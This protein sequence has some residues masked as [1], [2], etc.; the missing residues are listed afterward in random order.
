MRFLGFFGHCQ[1]LLIRTAPLFF[2]I[3]VVCFL[4]GSCITFV[5]GAEQGWFTFT[6]ACLIGGLFSRSWLA[7]V[8]AVILV[9]LSIAAAIDGRRRGI[10]YRPHLQRQGLSLPG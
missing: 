2:L 8:A 9:A 1:V 10:E 4:M 3:G 7:R 6:A 5:P